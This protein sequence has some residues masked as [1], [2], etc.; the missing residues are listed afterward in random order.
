MLLRD[1]DGPMYKDMNRNNSGRE[2]KPSVGAPVQGRVRNLEYHSR[3]NGYT[4]L[5]V[6]LSLGNV[7]TQSL[8]EILAGE[9]IH[10]WRETTIADIEECGR[11]PKCEYCYLCCGN[12]YLEHGTPLKPSKESCYM[13]EVRYELAQN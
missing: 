7:K 5:Y 6:P 3:W 8:K 10:R 1:P 12:N 13:A 4:L 9:A 2:A 11:H